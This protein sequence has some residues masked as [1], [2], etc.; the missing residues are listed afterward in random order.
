[1]QLRI[2]ILKYHLW[3]L[4]QI[5]LQIMLLPIQIDKLQSLLF[6]V[7]FISRLTAPVAPI[8][9][10]VPVI[11]TKETSVNVKVWHALQTNGPIR[12]ESSYLPL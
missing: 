10:D 7:L 6:A 4:C 1:M 2:T 8:N 9:H 5:S 3:Y 12:Y 11:E